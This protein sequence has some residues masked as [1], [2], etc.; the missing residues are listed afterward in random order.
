MQTYTFADG[1]I[2]TAGVV[3]FVD[4]DRL[5]AAVV[6]GSGAYAGVSGSLTSGAPV[7][8]YDS[9]DVLHLDR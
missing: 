3:R 6:G 7:Q 4:A 8:G 2:V 5:N 9:V 1:Q